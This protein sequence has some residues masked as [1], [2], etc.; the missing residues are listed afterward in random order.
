MSLNYSLVYKFLNSVCQHMNISFQCVTDI[1]INNFFLIKDGEEFTQIISHFLFKS[2]RGKQR[3][4]VSYLGRPPL[5]A[6]K[7][8]FVLR[9]RKSEKPVSLMKAL[10]NLKGGSKT[11]KI[12]SPSTTFYTSGDFSKKLSPNRFSKSMTRPVSR[13][14][15]IGKIVF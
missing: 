13:R 11:N 14:I 8:L 6:L 2:L 10:N 5:P 4:Q 7:F 9:I 15:A 1:K 12:H 3:Y